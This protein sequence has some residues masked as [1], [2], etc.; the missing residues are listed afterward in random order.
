MGNGVRRIDFT[1]INGVA[2]G[3]VMDL[4]NRWLPDGR[5][6][7]REFVAINPRRPDRRRGSFRINIDSGKWADFA[8]GESGGDLVSLAAYLAGVGQG[9][10]ARQLADMLGIPCHE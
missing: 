10:A 8:I 4:L 5:L 7:G 1:G 9:E 2:I 3:R 6:D